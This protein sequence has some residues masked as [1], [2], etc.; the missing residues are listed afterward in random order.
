[1]WQAQASRAVVSNDGKT[2]GDLITRIKQEQSD[3][4]RIIGIEQIRYF[5]WQANVV[6]RYQFDRATRLNGLAVGTAFR[7]RSAPVI[8]FARLGTLVD[9]SRPFLGSVSTNLDAFVQYNR[10]IGFANRKY[11]WS[12]EVRVKNVFDDRTLAPWIADDDGTGHAIIEERLRPNERQLAV[13]T[14]LGF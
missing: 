6:A 7:W 8:G 4:Q 10:A 5:R 9:P 12:A 11:R 14:S 13:S 2:V 1:V 3:D